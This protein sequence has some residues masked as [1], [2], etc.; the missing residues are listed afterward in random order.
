MQKR[1]SNGT[2]IVLGYSQYLKVHSAILNSL[3]RYETLY[4]AIQY[5]SFALINKP[6]MGVGRN[7]AYKKELFLKHG[8]FASHKQITG[9]DDDLF[10]NSAWRMEHG[11][12]HRAPYSNVAISINKESQTISKP[13]ENIYQWFIQKKRHL[14]AGKYYKTTDKIRLALLFISQLF[15][16][17]SVVWLLISQKFLLIA[18]FCF[19]L[20]TSLILFTFAQIIKKLGDTTKWYLIPLL[21]PLYVVYYLFIGTIALFSKKIRWN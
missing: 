9:G 7:L 16:Y 18:A 20:R 19:I 2:E 11:T 13:K 4:T 5:L 6:Y 1:F 3:I 17:I 14:A 21:D 15:F 8:G 10:V 12:G